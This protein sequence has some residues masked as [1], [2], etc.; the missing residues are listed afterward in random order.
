[1]G[2]CSNSNSDVQDCSY[3]KA[4]YFSNVVFWLRHTQIFLLELLNASFWV[5]LCCW[6]CS[7]AL[8][9]EET[10]F[11]SASTQVSPATIFLTFRL[12]YSCV[13]CLQ[14][15]A[16][17]A[18][19]WIQCSHCA[20]IEGKCWLMSLKQKFFTLAGW[21]VG[22]KMKPSLGS[23]WFPG[24]HI[25]RYTQAM[26]WCVGMGV[27]CQVRQPVL[28]LATAAANA[29]WGKKGLSKHLLV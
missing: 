16:L 9:M 8:T 7:C 26:E 19:E 21:Q 22:R 24:F 2:N 3:Y 11:L 4:N 23:V 13:S 10:A 20:A 17:L 29:V 18:K 1:M 12:I 6:W 15:L 28:N 5:W 27:C 25:W 14:F